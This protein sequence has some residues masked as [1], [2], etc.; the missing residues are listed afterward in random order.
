LLKKLLEHRHPP[1]PPLGLHHA[2][3]IIAI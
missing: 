3:V 2:G 1:P